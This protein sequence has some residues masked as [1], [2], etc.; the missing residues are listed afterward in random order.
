VLWPK[1][2]PVADIEVGDDGRLVFE[3]TDVVIAVDLDD[4]D[5]HALHAR[6]AITEAEEE[7][8][9]RPRLQ[10]PPKIRSRN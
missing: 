6:I 2:D 1:P 7:L 9:K 3:A 8:D 10:R 5:P 4:L